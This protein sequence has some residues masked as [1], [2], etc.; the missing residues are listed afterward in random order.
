MHCVFG[1]RE[2]LQELAMLNERIPVFD[3][4]THWSEPADVWESRAPAK[5]KGKVLHIK[6]QPD[7][8]QAWYVGDQRIH[9]A[10]AS[11]INKDSKR[12]L[13]TV[14]LQ[15]LDEIAPACYDAKKRVDMM[16]GQGVSTQIIYP[17][18]IGFGAQAMMKVS[19]DAKLRHWHITAFNDALAEMQTE[20]GKRLLP[21]AVLPLWDMDA[22]I[23]ELHRAREKLGLTGIAMSD[24]PADFG[25]KPLT[26]PIWDRFF[27]TCQDLELPINFHIASGSWEGNLDEWWSEDRTMIRPGNR[28]NGPLT[29]YQ[30]LKLFMNNMG[31]IANL[32]LLGICERYPRLKFVSVESGASWIP[33]VVQGMEYFWE[34]YMTE[35]EQAKFK[36]SPRQIFID[37]I[38]ASFWFENKNAVEFFVKDL[39]PDNLM[40]ETDF[41]HPA[42]LWGNVHDKIK[43]TL[44]GFSEEVQ[45]KICY[46]NAEKVYGVS[47]HR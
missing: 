29:V 27:A 13:Q 41:P 30:T 47:V 10:G 17:N 12:V 35:A 46:Q 5:Y 3:I 4:D 38:Y 19:N 14:S 21:Q 2:L 26:D 18:V 20:G 42:S 16:D 45:R 40:F 25:Q 31:D 1:G 39:G 23:K 15:R 36:R 8:A 28:L 7:R 43:E 33:F 44:S 6:E 24:K 9:W 11:V 22:T 32:V 37:Q 34:Q